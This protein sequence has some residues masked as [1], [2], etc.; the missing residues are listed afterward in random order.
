M[1]ESHLTEQQIE[2]YRRRTLVAG[3]RGACDRHL[4][5]CDACLRR[6]I[7]TRQSNI[8]FTALAEALLPTP[9]E[10]PFHLSPEELRRYAAG[11]LNQADSVIFESHLEDCAECKD[12]ARQLVLTGSGKT[13]QPEGERVRYSPKTVWE[14][15]KD[16]GWRLP[17]LRPAYVGGI[18]LAC[19]CVLLGILWAQSRFSGGHNQSAPSQIA[20]N[21]Q[22]QNQSITPS[23]DERSEHQPP[24]TE[25]TGSDDKRADIEAANL[26]PAASSQKQTR[27]VPETLVSLIDGN[28]KVTL[29]RHGNLVGLEGLAPSTRRAVV[30]AL[31]G[32]GL[33]RPDSLGSL[34]APPINLLDQSSKASTFNQLSPTGIVI[35]DDR[36]AFRWQPLGGASSYTISVFDS[37]FDLVMRSEPQTATQWSPP[38]PLQRGK[39]YFWEVTALK[40]GQEITSPVAP[41]PRAQFKIVEVEKL[42]EINRVKRARPDSHLVLGI[43]YAHAG[44]L[45]AA[46]REFQRLANANPRS[47][48]AGRLLRRVQAWGRR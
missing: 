6:V 33:K 10:E 11:R 40:D 13:P 27:T 24:P 1:T 25:T 28:R 29:D 21:A 35:V 22:D 37:N 30:T 31:S 5:T 43:L 48:V 47:Q 23:M 19:V 7:D 46:E 2:A 34:T 41:A 20:S 17:S 38:R 36:P 26:N 9:D 15:F 3:E 42:E 39:I 4:A 18:A 45:E 8:A 14:R 32:D 16:S 44:L 12:E